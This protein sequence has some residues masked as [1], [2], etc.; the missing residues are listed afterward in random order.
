MR[1]VYIGLSIALLVAVVAQFYFAAVGAFSEPQSDSSYAPHRMIG[2]M[3]IPLLS[4]LTIVAAAV[5]KAPG[6]LVGMAA[7]PLGLVIVQVLIV[8]LG[9]AFNDDAGNTTTASVVILGLHALVG[10]A[11]MGAAFGNLN[12]ARRFARGGDH[13]AVGGGV[14]GGG[15]AA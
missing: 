2:M 11:V 13:D 8:L 9:R 12:A 15:A 14:A 6:K 4:I 10:G 1:K 7:A 3:V 5:A